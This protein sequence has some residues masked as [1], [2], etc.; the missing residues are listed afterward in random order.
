VKEGNLAG[1]IYERLRGVYGDVCMGDSSGWGILRTKTRTSPISGAVVVRELLQLVD[2]LEG[3]GNNQCSSLRSDAHFVVRFLKNVRRRKL[4]SFNMTKRGLTLHVWPCRQFK[5]T[6]GI[7]SS[8]HPTVRIWPP[9]TITCSGY[10]TI[11]W[12]VTTTK[13][14]RQ[15]RKPCEADCEELEETCTSVI[16]KILQ[17]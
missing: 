10:W 15:S 16:V 17:R 3:G 13:L 6:V 2:F 14:M 5:R 7:C 12:E 9:Q 1:V 8:I 11:T 4:S